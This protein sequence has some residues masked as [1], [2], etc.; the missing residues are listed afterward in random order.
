MSRALAQKPVPNR[1]AIS[2]DERQKDDERTAWLRQPFIMLMS[3]TAMDPRLRKKTTRM[4][5]P[6]AASAAATVRMRARRPDRPVVQEE[7]ERH[8]VEVHRKQD[9]FD[10]HQDD[11]DVLA[12][13][14]DAEHAKREQDR[15][16]R[17]IMAK[18]MDMCVSNPLI[19]VKDRRQLLG[20][21]PDLTLTTSMAVSGVRAF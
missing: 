4:A 21:W 3:S 9:Q 13:E 17:E 16:D 5:R 2:A 18:S 20:P 11:D 12:V 8:Q 14:E 6:M 15:P 1:P 10:R 19:A 7:R